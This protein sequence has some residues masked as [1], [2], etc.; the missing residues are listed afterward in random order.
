MNKC[1]KVLHIRLLCWWWQVV[2]TIDQFLVINTQR[3]RMDQDSE[4]WILV[5]FI[6][7]GRPSSQ[8]RA[9][10][11]GVRALVFLNN[12]CT[13][14]EEPLKVLNCLTNFSKSKLKDWV[15]DYFDV[16]LMCWL[17]SFSGPSQGSSPPPPHHLLY[18]NAWNIISNTEHLKKYTTNE[19]S[20]VLSQNSTIQLA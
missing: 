3:K 2:T 14:E 19:Y 15:V 12:S 8:A 13:H 10:L 16:L 18:R 7:R 1:V 4:I 9:R 5:V 20:Y 11:T 6:I 17:D